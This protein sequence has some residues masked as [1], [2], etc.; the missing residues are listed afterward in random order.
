MAA[1]SGSSVLVVPKSELIKAVAI[2]YSLPV[3]SELLEQRLALC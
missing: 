2:K 1:E 3:V